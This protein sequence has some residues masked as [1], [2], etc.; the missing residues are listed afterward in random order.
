MQVTNLQSYLKKYPLI[1]IKKKQIV[2][3][4]TLKTVY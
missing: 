4:E 1:D 3:M 2:K